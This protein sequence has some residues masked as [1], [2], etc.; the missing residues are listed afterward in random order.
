MKVR[1]VYRERSD[2]ARA[3]ID[4]LHD[5]KRR[6]DKELETVDPD[7]RGGAD[8]CRLYDVVEYPTV[9]ATNDDGVVLNQWRGLPL[10]T[11]NEVSYYVQ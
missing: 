7:S 5:F 2:H 6:T 4:Y 10:P 1:I 11:I 8:I 3:V 9:I